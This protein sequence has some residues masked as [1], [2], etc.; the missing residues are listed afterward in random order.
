[1]LRKYTNNY[2]D[3]CRELI[4][5]KPPTISVSQHTTSSV[6]KIHTNKYIEHDLSKPI[7]RSIRKKGTDKYENAHIQ[8]VAIEFSRRRE[9]EH[10]T[11][12]TFV[13]LK[14]L[15]YKRAR[16]GRRQSVRFQSD[17]CEVPREEKKSHV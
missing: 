4:I 9:R 8:A 15:D 7:T 11:S 13:R 14:V 10:S 16:Q 12:R 5:S 6:N 1:M 2:T 3:K 17:L